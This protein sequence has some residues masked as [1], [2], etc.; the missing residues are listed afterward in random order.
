MSIWKKA[1]CLLMIVAVILCI[2][3][4]FSAQEQI[5]LSVLYEYTSESGRDAIQQSLEQYQKE[6]PHI[7]LDIQV[8]TQARW[9]E[10]MRMRAV[11]ND[12]PDIS[13]CVPQR[14]SEWALAGKLAPGNDIIPKVVLNKYDEARM[15]SV[16]HNDGQIYG[17]P[18]TDAIRAV[19]Y[20]VDYFKKA[21]ITPP[22]KAEDAWTW[23]EL[24]EAA[25][26]AQAASG[27]K[28]A[29]QFEKASFDGWLPFIYQAGA[30]LMNEDYTESTVKTPEFR[31]ALEWT[32]KLHEEEI[33]APGI[34]EGIED[35]VRTFA[36]GLTTMWLA[37][38]HWMMDAL[39]PQMQCEYAYTFL[40]K[41]VQQ[42][43]VVGGTDWVVF[44]GPH[45]KEAWDLLLYMVSSG[46]MASFNQAVTSVPPRSDVKVD[47]RIHPEF[48]T[49]F[50]EQARQM[51]ENLLIHQLHPA[52]GACRDKLLQE[53]SACVSGQKSVDRT[54]DAMDRI[55][56][57][58]LKTHQY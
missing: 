57:D 42:A 48:A 3:M 38:G 45:S 29:L 24:V 1:A 47:W 58:A 44:E 49:L 31:R 8:A 39:D 25:K 55:M 36:S 19:A 32:V 43:T 11:A 54:L 20:N 37:T 33:A 50:A 23:E 14:V 51:P 40:P 4:S 18:F 15:L 27:A 28:Y 9:P 2:T 41:D 34:I 22:Q 26:K 16:I 6:N 46:P 52:Y 30:E 17:L 10:L 21:G 5:T 7:K 53:L 35:P 56:Q 13:T 12:Y